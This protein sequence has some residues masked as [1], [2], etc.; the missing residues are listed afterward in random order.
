MLNSAVGLP[1][2]APICA[3]V[4]AAVLGAGCGERS[5]P[6]GSLPQSYPVSVQGAGDRPTVL[7]AQPE[8]IVALNP[9]SAELLIALGVGT[10]LVGVPAGLGVRGAGKADEVVRPAGQLE[11]DAI[12]ALKPDLIVATPDIDQLDL[13][14]MARESGAAVYFQPATSIQNVEDAAIDLGFLV[15][16]AA[17]ARQLVGRI[18]RKV[19]E[20]ER[21]L[22][23]VEPVSVFVDTGF[24]IT[25]PERSLL[26]DL[27]SKAKGKSIAGPSPG[28]GPFSLADLSRLNPD[29]YL[30]TSDSGV[31][32]AALRNN[33]ATARLKAVRKK[34]LALVPVALVTRPGPRVADGLEAIA[35]A[36]HPDAF[37]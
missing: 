26:G 22:V 31:T 33:P 10:K 2:L 25:V 19:A 16:E 17:R 23:S 30:A 36:L 7:K 28:P 37:R 9:G 4:A 29:I 34:R 6:V 3:L 21:R 5:E 35:R 24:F 20:V 15:G 12:V 1:R 18:E 11:L 8:R 27:V 32:L 13:A 14:R